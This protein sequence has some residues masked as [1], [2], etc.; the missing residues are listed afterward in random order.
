MLSATTSPAAS[1]FRRMSAVLAWGCLLAA[2]G[3]PILTA[4]VWFA[5]P[6]VEVFQSTLR[7]APLDPAALTE[8]FDLG[9]RALGFALA[10][11]PA[12]FSVPAL[13]HARRCLSLFAEGVRFD[14][15]IVAAL[16]GFSGMTALQTATGF[17][18]QAPITLVLT[19]SQGPG[20]REIALGIGS[21]QIYELFFAGVVWLIASVMAEAA[22]IAR[23]N[24]E[25]V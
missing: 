21:E 24:S 23:E 10:L 5:M 4:W 8:W 3:I 2:I 7:R 16:R 1:R 6:P 14:R 11:V 18:V 20:R 19:Y 9:P 13:L 25:F 15:R 17:L 22:D 12:L